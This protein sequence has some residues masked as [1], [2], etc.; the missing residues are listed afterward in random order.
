MGQAYEAKGGISL[1]F[2]AFIAGIAGLSHMVSGL[3]GLY[4]H[5]THVVVDKI[6]YHGYHLNPIEELM[7]NM[8]YRWRPALIVGA[9]CL[10]A[11]IALFKKA[12]NRM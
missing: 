9:V 1:K 5:K 11:A 7:H 4:E 2:L 12:R 3:L 10:V 8:E 6:I